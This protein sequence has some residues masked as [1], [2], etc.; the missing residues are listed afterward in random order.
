VSSSSRQKIIFDLGNQVTTNVSPS[1]I[2]HQQNAHKSQ[3][4]G[5]YD[6][7]LTATFFNAP[8]NIEAADR[9]IPISARLGVN[10][11]TESVFTLP[12][13]N[14]SN[15]IDFPRNANRVFFSLSSCGQASK[16]VWWIN[17]LTSYI[18]AFT[19]VDRMLFG[20]SPFREVQVYIDDQLA[21]VQWPF[22]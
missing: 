21:G 2:S 6:T 12:A 19:A 11:S 4:T 13:V 3:L 16:E 17:V 14:A 9:I 7:A 1:E 20:F 8:Q 18:L 22:V 10:F 15:T 5:A